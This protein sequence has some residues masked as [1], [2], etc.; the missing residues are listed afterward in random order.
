M[1]IHIIQPQM[2]DFFVF[3]EAVNVKL[4]SRHS[5]HV[6][7]PAGNTLFLPWGTS[8]FNVYYRIWLWKVA[9]TWNQC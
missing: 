5:L 2:K 7:D 9:I 8:S 6:M 3:S 1:K 4:K